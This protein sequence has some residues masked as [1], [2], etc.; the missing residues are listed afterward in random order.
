MSDPFRECPFPLIRD[1]EDRQLFRSLRD[2]IYN[3]IIE[4]PV[5]LV[6]S[7]EHKDM[8]HD[9]ISYILNKKYWWL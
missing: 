1:K 6:G 7:P 5:D 8:V 2:D 9:T 3:A 4:L